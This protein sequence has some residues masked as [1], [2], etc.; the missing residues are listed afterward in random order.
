VDL[1]VISFHAA[2]EIV[3]EAKRRVKWRDRGAAGGATRGL[4]LHKVGGVQFSR[5]RSSLGAIPGKPCFSL[6]D[7]SRYAQT[8]RPRFSLFPSRV[9]APGSPTMNRAFSFLARRY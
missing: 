5:L 2:L 8:V 1:C 3:W 4:A 6:S 9:I 7:H